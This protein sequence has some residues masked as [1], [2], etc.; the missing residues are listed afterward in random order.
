MAQP[1]F[2]AGQRVSVV[3]SGAFS[4]PPGAYRV[5]Q[6]LPHERGAQ[7][8]RV[9]NDAEAYDRILD[10]ARLEAVLHE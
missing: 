9:R 8:Y 2:S 1:K 7:Q 5:V 3:R 10:E 6:P 4:A